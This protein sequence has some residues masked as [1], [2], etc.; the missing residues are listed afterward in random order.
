MFEL[1]RHFMV[2]NHTSRE[3]EVKRE[4]ERYYIDRDG[5]KKEREG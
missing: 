1:N 4:K 5:E 2:Q 3:R